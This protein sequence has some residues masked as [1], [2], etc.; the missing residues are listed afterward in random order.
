MTRKIT[1]APTLFAI[2]MTSFAVQAHAG[3]ADSLPACYNHVISACNQTAHPVPCAESGMDA[4]DE[5]H[6]SGA[7]ATLDRIRILAR[8]VGGETT[9]RAII[10]TTDPRPPRADDDDNDNDRERREPAERRLPAR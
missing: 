7:A 2:A 8:T 3:A 5:L 4:C 6:A 1:L 9:Y 10:E